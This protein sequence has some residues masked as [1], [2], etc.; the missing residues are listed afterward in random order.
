LKGKSPLKEGKKDKRGW[1]VS[2][3]VYSTTIGYH[4]TT[5]VPHVPP[6]P[7]IWTYKSIPKIDLFVW[8]LAHRG[9]LTGENLRRRDW[10]GPHKCP[11]C[12]Q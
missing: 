11:L 7:A 3:G 9:I 5:A 2:S 8:T 1:G 4:H 10:E 12:T 6:D